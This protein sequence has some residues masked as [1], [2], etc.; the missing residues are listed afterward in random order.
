VQPGPS[1]RLAAAARTQ[2]S[3]ASRTYSRCERRG[4]ARW[5]AAA[6]VGDVVPTPLLHFHGSS[7]VIQAAIEGQGVALAHS[8]LVA[9]DL[10]A[11]RLVRPFKISPLTEYCYYLVWPVATAGTPKIEAFRGWLL[12]TVRGQAEREATG[13]MLAPG[14]AG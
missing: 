2:R 1:N 3:A 10:A 4:L 12:D 14:G 11:G 5:L 13:P 8:A 6:G 9:D 7:L